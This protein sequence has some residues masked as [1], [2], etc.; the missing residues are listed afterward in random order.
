[1][2]ATSTNRTVPSTVLTSLSST[3]PLP[4]AATNTP[5]PPTAKAPTAAP[6]SKLPEGRAPP[7]MDHLRTIPSPPPPRTP[8]SK[9]AAQLSRPEAPR[10][11]TPASPLL[12][13]PLA[14]S[15]NEPVY[16]E[17]TTTSFTQPLLMAARSFVVLPSTPALMQTPP[18][19][20]L[21]ELISSTSKT[22][23]KPSLP[24][25]TTPPPTMGL[26]LVTHLVW[27]M[28][29]FV[30]LQVATSHS[31]RVPPTPPVTTLPVPAPRLAPQVKGW[32]F[33]SLNL[34]FLLEMFP[35]LS[36]QNIA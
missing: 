13:D 19:S 10:A 34:P 17:S 23:T 4:R 5:F 3:T 33:P 16:P 11:L 25:V 8:P 18:T 29:F 6:Q 36:V 7:P 14:P 27:A 20:K 1:M 24:L 15:M 21:L 26:T 12:Q 2:V 22:F 9:P 30:T 35:P 32:I 31:M 28:V